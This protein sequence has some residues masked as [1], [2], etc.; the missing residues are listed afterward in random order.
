MLQD[1]E[2]FGK[3]LKDFERFGC[4]CV[5]FETLWK[6]WKDVARVGKM[7][8]DVMR[9]WI[10]VERCWYMLRNVERLCDV[11]KDLDI[12]GEILRDG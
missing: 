10:Y 4:S 6:I 12:F 8:R 2:R 7:C 9:C 1:V 3:I 11:L 5:E